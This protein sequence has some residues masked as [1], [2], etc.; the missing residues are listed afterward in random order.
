M[1]ALS[2]YSPHLVLLIRRTVSLFV[3]RGRRILHEAS[4]KISPLKGPVASAMRSGPPV[5]RPAVARPACYT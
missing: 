2:H 1:N 5:P 4:G 3:V